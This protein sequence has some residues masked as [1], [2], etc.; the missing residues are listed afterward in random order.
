MKL[1]DLYQQGL[2]A[3]VV[4]IY[5]E[6]GFTLSDLDPESLLAIPAAFLALSNFLDALTVCEQI[7]PY[8]PDNPNFYSLYGSVLRR[9]GHLDKARNVY[10]KALKSFPDNPIVLN[11][12][13]NLLLDLGLHQDAVRYLES[14]LAL[15]PSYQ[16]AK[17]NLVHAKSLLASRQSF[18]QNPISA[19]EKQ[20]SD[21]PLL[22]AFTQDEVDP[23]IAKSNKA[24]SAQKAIG[25]SIEEIESI[26]GDSR[27]KESSNSNLSP[28]RIEK[29]SELLALARNLLGVDNKRVLSYCNSAHEVLGVSPEVYELAA[30]AYI[31]SKMFPDAEVSLLTALSLGFNNPS[32][33]VNLAT[34]AQMRGDH[35]LSSYYLAKLKTISPSYPHIQSIENHHNKN[36]SISRKLPFQYNPEQAQDG[37]FSTT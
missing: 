31:S 34:L 36:V 21:D 30:Q 7:S 22:D 33:Y 10:E 28:Q 3:Q 27:N 26:L 4:S 14:A 37:N 1:S 20:N 16:D 8:L 5:K 9:N 15:D 17:Q 32:I 35:D 6:P 19:P 2:H 13:S 23:F 12:Y 18:Q 25:K 24:S 11:N 29:A